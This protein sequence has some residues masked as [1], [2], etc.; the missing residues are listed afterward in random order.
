[1][2]GL[3]WH[4]AVCCLRQGPAPAWFHRRVQARFRTLMPPRPLPRMIYVVGLGPLGIAVT[5]L[6]TSAHQ[7]ALVETLVIWSSAWIYAIIEVLVRNVRDV[8]RMGPDLYDQAVQ[9]TRDHLTGHE[10]LLMQ[11]HA[12]TCA[13][14]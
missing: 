13:K 3:V 1:M 9:S 7:A 5:L 4:M 8:L 6:W 11:Q 2:T 10:R 14:S 12:R